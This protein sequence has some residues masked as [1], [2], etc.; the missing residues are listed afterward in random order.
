M[1]NCECHLAAGWEGQFDIASDIVRDAASICLRGNCKISIPSC[2][3]DKSNL[4]TNS[5]VV[6]VYLLVMYRPSSSRGAKSC[7]SRSH[8]VGSSSILLQD[9]LLHVLG[10]GRFH[11]FKVL[12]PRFSLE[13]LVCF[14]L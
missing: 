4:E 7:V 9:L 10:V 1:R 6:D 13:P 12:E 3:K 5:I 8:H 2:S 14:S 11:P